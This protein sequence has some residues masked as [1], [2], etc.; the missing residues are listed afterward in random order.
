[1]VDVRPATDGDLAPINEL[2]NHY[3][4]HTHVTFDLAPFTMDQRREWFSHYATTGRHRLLVAVE[5][6]DVLGYASS[7]PFRPKEAYETSVETSVYLR[8]E[9]TGRGVGRLLYHELLGALEREDVHRAYGGIAVPN[10][11]SIA[12]HERMGFTRAGYFTEQG[13]KHGR[14]WDVVWYERPV[15]TR[16]VAQADGAG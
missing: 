3:V 14:Y 11:A 1:M 9:A 8:P 12:L 7:S 4:V 2:Y 16:P 6:N 13:R 10:E 15:G 5:G